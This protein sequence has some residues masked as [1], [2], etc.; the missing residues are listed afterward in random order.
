MIIIHPTNPRMIETGLANRVM[1]ASSVPGF[2]KSI[3]ILG[4]TNAVQ[5]IAQRARAKNTSV[6][7]N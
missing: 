7:I 4:M 1:R 6:G 3:P 5:K 2:E